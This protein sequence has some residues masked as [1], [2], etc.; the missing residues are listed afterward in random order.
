[1]S[2]IAILRGIRPEE[3]LDVGSIL[4]DAGFDTIEI[5]LNSPTPFRSIELL[6]AR[7][8]AHCRCGAGTVLRPEDVERVKAA[9][10]TL[11]VTPNINTEVIH[12]TLELGLDVLPGFG[13]ATEALCAVAAGAEDLKLFPA[14]S[15]GPGH[16]GAIRS[17]LPPQI[18]ITAVGGISAGNLAQWGCADGV[19]IGSSLFAPGMPPQAV[20]LAARDTVARYRA[21]ETARWQRV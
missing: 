7:F 21:V 15:Y 4:V 3:V 6:C 2:L 8:G 13:T 9:G 14:A 20:A 12:R 5:P 11:I 19:A 1:M 16:L 17:I 10:G 18:R